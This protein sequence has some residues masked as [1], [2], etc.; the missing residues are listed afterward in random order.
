M[1]LISNTLLAQTTQ[2]VGAIYSSSG[3]GTRTTTRL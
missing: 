1:Q 3:L 2:T